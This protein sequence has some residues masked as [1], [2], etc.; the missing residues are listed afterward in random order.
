V[1]LLRQFRTASRQPRR[2]LGA[3]LIVAVAL[4]A[5]SLGGCAVEHRTNVKNVTQDDLAAGGEPYFTAGH[6]TYQVQISRQLNPY[7]NEDVQYLAGI[8]DAQ[9]LPGNQMW[10]GVFLWAKNQSGSFALTANNFEMVDS[11]GTVYHPVVLK[12]SINPYA[13][14]QRRLA[15]NGTEPAYDTTASWGPTG[16]SLILFD[17]SA[18]VYSNRPLFLRIFPPGGGRPSNIALDL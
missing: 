2:A 8:S 13:W 5:I 9:T 7:S 14:T 15:P 12:P 18:L 3:P 6:V 11:A 4:L 17:V 1:S 16:G 10:F